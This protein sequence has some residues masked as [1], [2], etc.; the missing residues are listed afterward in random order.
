MNDISGGKVNEKKRD[1]GVGLRVSGFM[2]PAA[3]RPP[4][5]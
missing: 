1:S 4:E 5:A 2:I 3:K